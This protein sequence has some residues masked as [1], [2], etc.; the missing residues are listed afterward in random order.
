[1]DLCRFD[2]KIINNNVLI[3]GADLDKVNQLLSRLKFEGEA[4]SI[5]SIQNDQLFR[6]IVPE[7]SRHYPISASDIIYRIFQK[8]EHEPDAMTVY[9]D[10][11]H[12]N[13][14]K[15]KDFMK[16]YLH[17]HFY[18]IRNVVINLFSEHHQIKYLSDSIRYNADYTIFMPTTFD[19]LD[20]LIRNFPNLFH[21]QDVKKI[22][23]LMT[24]CQ[25]NNV[26]LVVYYDKLVLTWAYV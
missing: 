26:A 22:R 17:G 23:A 1:M 11:T 20:I 16:L 8:Q 7:T 12:L 10:L 9:T 21:D 19:N 24:I 4:L 3:I 2:K 18:N 14:E 6:N 25:Y 15:D 5:S 13:L